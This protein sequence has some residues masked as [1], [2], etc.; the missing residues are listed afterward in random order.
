MAY[1][2][3]SID[4]LQDSSTLASAIANNIV[5]KNGINI[6]ATSTASRGYSGQTL[7]TSDLISSASG[8]DLL[9]SGVYG[10]MYRTNMASISLNSLATSALGSENDDMSILDPGNLNE[11]GSPKII[12]GKEA[13]LRIVAGS[14]LGRKYNEGLIDGFADILKSAY[15]AV[16]DGSGHSDVSSGSD[17]GAVSAGYMPIALESK[18]SEVEKAAYVARGTLLKSS[19]A[20][21]PSSSLTNGFTFDINN[22]L[23][24]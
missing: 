19:A 5:P 7:T 13:G 12:K 18:L 10:N 17:S 6:L 9:A 3:F 2:N 23:Q 22:S 24:I 11:D 21:T 4:D 20:I 8:K 16:A 15:T 1:F 14:Q